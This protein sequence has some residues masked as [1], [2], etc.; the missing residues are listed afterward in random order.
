M[1]LT[2]DD[3]SALS[4]RWLSKLLPR[5]DIRVSAANIAHEGWVWKRSRYLMLWRRRWMILCLDGKLLTF[6]DSSQHGGATEQFRFCEVAAEDDTDQ[7][8]PLQI[9]VEPVDNQ[10]ASGTKPR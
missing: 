7:S 10:N 2:N 3:A 6:E 5:Q 4:A 1:A 9:S 8:Q